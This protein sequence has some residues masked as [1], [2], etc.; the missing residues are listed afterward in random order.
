MITYKWLTCYVETLIQITKQKANEIDG[1]L[2]Y[3]MIIT[4]KVNST[5]R[6][7]IGAFQ[8]H[9]TAIS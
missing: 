8:V 7:D 9:S 1:K 6:K 2:C 3:I 5:S 4:A